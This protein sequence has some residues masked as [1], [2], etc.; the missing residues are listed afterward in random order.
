MNQKIITSLKLVLF[1]IPFCA[2]FAKETQKVPTPEKSVT[3]VNI[4]TATLDDL[5]TLPQIGPAIA[6][7]I[8]DFRTEHKSFGSI[9][10]IMNVKGIGPKKFE[11]IKPL[12]KLK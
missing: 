8:I 9:E 11:K 2:G 10:E 4:N 3:I 12:I 7:R 1:L 5:V 6:Q